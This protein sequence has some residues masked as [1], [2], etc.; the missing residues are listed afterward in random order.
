MIDRR[1]CLTLAAAAGIAPALGRAPARAQPIIYPS[2]PVYLVVPFAPAGGADVVARLLSV[3]LSEMWGQQVIVENRSGAGGNIAAEQV[4]RAAPDGYTL[5]L[6]SI[7]HAINKFLFSSLNYD[8]VADFAPVS[9]IC[10]Y[11]NIMVVPMS[12]PVH[13]VQEFIEYAKARPGRITFASSSNGTSVHL[14]G[15]LFKRMAHIEMTHIPYRGAGPAYNDV[16]PGRIDV[17]FPTASS[18][19][20]LMDA[21]K[22]RAL[23]VT[24]RE[25]QPWAPDLPTVAESGLPGFEV[26]S[27]Y[28]LFAPAKTPPEIIGKINADA[29]RVV[30]DPDQVELLDKIATTAV[31]STPEELARHLQS[32]MDKW[33]PIITAAKIRVNA[34]E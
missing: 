21:G 10:T 23:A 12:S 4:A 29:V 30:R 28:G 26:S 15:E 9:L 22:L 11:P 8:P 34:N 17:M 14:A 7:G 18:A 5:F 6:V 27:W 31:G 32:E 25:R 33:G 16:I 19:V 20:P 1:R 24:S 3:H 13:T 2:R